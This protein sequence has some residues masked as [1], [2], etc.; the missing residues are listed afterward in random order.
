MQPRCTPGMVAGARVPCCCLTRPPDMSP[1]CRGQ[2]RGCDACRGGEEAGERPAARLPPAGPAGAE[3]PAAR[4]VTCRARGVPGVPHPGAW[5]RVRPGCRQVRPAP[6][7]PKR[8]SCAAS[9]LHS[10]TLPCAV[11]YKLSCVHVAHSHYAIT[12]ALSIEKYFI[13]L[14]AI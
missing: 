8:L 1:I 5:R 3:D 13:I 10:L 4:P 11:L 12:A 9:V 2:G 14:H 7:L 6:S